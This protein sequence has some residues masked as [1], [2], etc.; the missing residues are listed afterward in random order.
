MGNAAVDA[1]DGDTDMIFETIEWSTS[2]QGGTEERGRE[3]CTH[4]IHAVII[5]PYIIQ[6][7][8]AGAGGGGVTD[9][10]WTVPRYNNSTNA[11]Y[12]AYFT[13]YVHIRAL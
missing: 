13:T 9:Q 4:V 12:A 11:P 5:T 2:G 6:E 7:E 3:E 8:A 10:I 1:S